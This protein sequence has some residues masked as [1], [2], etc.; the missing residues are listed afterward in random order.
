MRWTI[1]GLLLAAGTLHVGT[2]AQ[3]PASSPLRAVQPED[4]LRLER[5]WNATFSPDGQLLSYWVTRSEASGISPSHDAL[6]SRQRI[7]IWTAAVSGGATTRIA[8]G[9]REGIGYEAPR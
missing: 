5:L 7:E 8:S 3:A 1:V 9:E 2:A 6:R 4:A